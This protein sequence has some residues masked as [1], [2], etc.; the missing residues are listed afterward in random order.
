MKYTD[1]PFSKC[2]EHV[3]QHVLFFV[4]GTG[5]NVLFCEKNI[6]KCFILFSRILLRKCFVPGQRDGFFSK[7]RRTL[8]PVHMTNLS[9][10]ISSVRVNLRVMFRVNIRFAVQHCVRLMIGGFAVVK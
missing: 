9:S 6:L 8:S 4:P 2:S 7:F 5:R 1:A 3:L 10:Y